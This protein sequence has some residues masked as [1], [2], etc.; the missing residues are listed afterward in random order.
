MLY[1]KTV[2]YNDHFSSSSRE[3]VISI[4]F[5]TCRSWQTF[6]TPR[7]HQKLNKPFLIQYIRKYWLVYITSRKEYPCLSQWANPTTNDMH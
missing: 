1:V 7:S 4:L 2:G 6:Q 5:Q 3:Q